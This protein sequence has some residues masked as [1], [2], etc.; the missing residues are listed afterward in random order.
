MMILRIIRLHLVISFFT[1]VFGSN[2]I[3][4]EYSDPY[5]CRTVP[6]DVDP[7]SEQL[8]ALYVEKLTVSAVDI[9]GEHECKLPST[10]MPTKGNYLVASFFVAGDVGGLGSKTKYY[11]EKHLEENGKSI[12]WCSSGINVTKLHDDIKRLFEP[13]ASPEHTESG[14]IEYIDSLTVDML[15]R[16][17]SFMEESYLQ[18]FD[19]YGFHIESKYNM[20]NRC[21]KKMFE[22]MTEKIDINFFTKLKAVISDN[23]RRKTLHKARP[24]LIWTC[25]SLDTAYGDQVVRL[26]NGAQSFP[27]NYSD[28]QY[29]TPSLTLA[30]GKKEAYTGKLSVQFDF[31]QDAEIDFNGKKLKLPSIIIHPLDFFSEQ[32]R[33][34]D[35]FSYR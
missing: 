19:S 31:S 11:R 35:N 15:M 2:A 25:R 13:K 24:L 26:H 8:A 22:Y 18:K 14:F 34:Y 1:V 4:L 28:A 7:L 9:F 21:F 32:R 23:E 10:D 12:L 33:M 6:T 5:F 27:M 29:N 17:D 3:A 16:F 20:C 30:L